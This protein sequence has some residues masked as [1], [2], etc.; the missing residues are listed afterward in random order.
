MKI[1]NITFSLKG[2]KAVL[3][4]DLIFNSGK[5]HEV[6][7]EVDKKHKDFISKDASPFL[8]AA[9]AICMKKNEDLEIDGSVSKYLMSST[10]DIMKILKS[11]D[12]GFNPISIKAKLYIENSNNN[13]NVGCFF[14]GGVDSF[15]TYLKNRQK[16]K[17]LI[18]VHGFDISANDEEL[19][20]KIEKNIMKIANEENVKLIKVKTNVREIFDQYFDWIVSHEFA[21]ASVA[22]FL[23]R[24]FKEIY[25]SCGLTNV[26]ADH[27][28]MSPD[29]D[30]L[31]STESMKIN[32][33]GC[34][35]NKIAKLRFLSHSELA[36]KNLRVCWVNKKKA[37]NCC[38]CEKCLRN[39]LGLY[40]SGS[41]GKCESFNKGLDLEKIKKIRVDEYVIK[42]FIAIL[43][44]LK[45]KGERSSVRDALEVCIENN[46]KPKFWQKILWNSRD[47]IRFLDQKY[48][49]NRLYWFFAKKG[50]VN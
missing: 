8:A 15:Y 7:F 26:N 5:K 10:P 18:F 23:R 16:I 11:W 31:W 46:T 25:A 2:H 9:L 12:L 1:A 40:L 35:A 34:D 39:M 37:Y 49:S 36:M 27:H 48:N 24:G 13:N 50:L 30:I 32:H 6:Y 29:L 38:E 45:I 21:I 14:S 42:H 17:Y 41:L 22:L 43:E 3:S 20:K 33:Y 44:V 4:A 19:Y 47:S 28:Y